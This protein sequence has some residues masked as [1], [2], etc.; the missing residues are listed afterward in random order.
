MHKV[1]LAIKV[2]SRVGRKRRIPLA[3]VALSLAERE[4]LYT[5]LNENTG[6]SRDVQEV[7]D[8]TFATAYNKTGMINTS[9]VKAIFAGAKRIGQRQKRARELIDKRE[10]R[11]KK[12]V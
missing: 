4:K 3:G 6:K 5:K 12:N 7:I 11:G 2:S 1:P 9:S 8:K 10:K